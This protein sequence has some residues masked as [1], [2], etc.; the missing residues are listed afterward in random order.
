MP[1]NG[2]HKRNR[3]AGLFAAS[4]LS[5]LVWMLVAGAGSLGGSTQQGTLPWKP[6]PDT[7]DQYAGDEMCLVCHEDMST[8]FAANP[9][10]SATSALG[11]PSGS[12]SCEA[13]HGPG[14]PHADAGG[15]PEL[16]ARIFRD[17]GTA[18]TG[19][20]C[21]ACH[22][23][24]REHAHA[25]ASTHAAADVSCSTCHSIHA[26][27]RLAALLKHPTPSLCLDCHPGV[28][29]GF[30][31]ADRHGLE[32]GLVSCEACHSPHGSIEPAM[33][34]RPMLNGELC[35][36]CHLDKR[37]PFVYQH[38][39]GTVE[40]CAACHAPHGSANRFMLKTN[41]ELGLCIS[42]HPGAV[43]F[44]NLADQRYRNCTTC[45][46]AIHGSD[47]HRLFFRR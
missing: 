4:V 28:K 20:T 6:M 44:H 11:H 47:T 24:S 19:E 32:K 10:A 17:L 35:S 22:A 9:H 18:E 2:F 34:A 12:I 27:Q 33:L 23:G 38:A 13:C 5:A 39:S 41:E 30:M 25:M 36:A 43:T 21:L 1:T 15:D 42:C 14:M 46:A 26:A 31:A 40:G 7:E 37:G 8:G 45:H 29:A 3:P 16:V